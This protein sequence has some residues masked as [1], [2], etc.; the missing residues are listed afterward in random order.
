[1]VALVL[2]GCATS[3]AV[4]PRGR[5]RPIPQYAEVPQAIP[6]HQVYLYQASPADGTLRAL[7]TRW[8]KDTRVELSYLHP[9]DYTLHA[10]VA[11]VRTASAEAAV[12]ALAAAYAAQGVRISTE[13]GR[14][15]VSQQVP[16]APGAPASASAH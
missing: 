11:Q 16:G 4:D 8:A 6:L 13:R 3:E 9:N 12:N 15:V 7:L 10:P 14:I 2:V 1:M 5:W